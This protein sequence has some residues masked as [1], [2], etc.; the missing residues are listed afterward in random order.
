MFCGELVIVEVFSHSKLNPLY[1]LPL[2]DVGPPVEVATDDP[3]T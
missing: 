3:L 1:E 2:F